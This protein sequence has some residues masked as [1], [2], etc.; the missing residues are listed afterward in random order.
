MSLILESM[1]SD[2]VS[3]VPETPGL[4]SLRSS[5]IGSSGGLLQ[6]GDDGVYI[7]HKIV[8]P[9]GAILDPTFFM[10]DDPL[11]RSIFPSYTQR[12]IAQWFPANLNFNGFA[13]LYIEYQPATDLPP[14]TS[15]S[16]LIPLI[17]QYG[18]LVPMEG[19]YIVDRVNK[20]VIVDVNGI[21]A[22]GIYG[23]GIPG[24]TGPDGQVIEN[25]HILRMGSNS[26][27]W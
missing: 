20:V 21:S 26:I 15:E 17:Y 10:V 14:H 1:F 5:Y 22:E 13:K 18:R 24:A 16:D 27:I 2:L 3:A 8:V 6:A 25:E 7:K 4:I 19:K 23:V 12:T 11:D 9:P